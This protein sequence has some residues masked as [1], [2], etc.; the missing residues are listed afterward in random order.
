M[1]LEGRKAST[2]TNLS[3]IYVGTPREYSLR[4]LDTD[5]AHAFTG[6]K[7]HLLN[8]LETSILVEDLKTCGMRAGRLRSM[9]RFFYRSW[10]ELADD[11]DRWLVSDEERELHAL[12]KNELQLHEGVLEPELSNLARRTVLELGNKGSDQCLSRIGFDHVFVDDYQLLSRASQRLCC[13]LAQKT[14]TVAADP[15]GSVQAFES[16]PYAAGVDEFVELF[17]DAR[18]IR[19]NM[20]SQAKAVRSSYAT[21][22]EREGLESLPSLVPDEAPEG[23]VEALAFKSPDEECVSIARL[24]ARQMK[25]DAAQNA[26]APALDIVAVVPNALWASSLARAFQT[27]GVKV[28]YHPDQRPWLSGFANGAGSVLARMICALRLVADPSDCLAW[29]SW[30]AFGDSMANSPVFDGIKDACTSQGIGLIEALDRLS[31]NNL[32]LKKGSIGVERVIEACREGQRILKMSKGLYGTDL[33]ELLSSLIRSDKREQIVDATLNLV[34]I[35]RSSEASDVSKMNAS[36]MLSCIRRAFEGPFKRETVT[37]GVFTYKEAVGMQADEAYIL[38]FVNG[39]IPRADWFDLT[40]TPAGKQAERRR[41]DARFAGTIAS[42]AR[43]KLTFSS[44]AS[45]NLDFAS[46]MKLKIDRIRIEDGTRKAVISPSIFL[47]SFL[48]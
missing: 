26:A 14:V 20:C 29:R 45:V 12:V 22:V 32:Q 7:A 38:G 5:E 24:I 15:Y 46:K 4:I 11:D 48:D 18:T 36:E 44:F 37:V 35:G 39:F 28:H 17:P 33:L 13:L 41:K 34:R 9:L 21:F 25:D 3:R 2:P 42:I 19:L 40:V 6:R 47:S 23:I 30:C 8:D 16:Y 43:N 31:S 1:R 10:T 27:E